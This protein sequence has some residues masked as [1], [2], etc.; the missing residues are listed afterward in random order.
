MPK[1]EYRTS[2]L[3]D[4]ERFFLDETCQGGTAMPKLNLFTTEDKNISLEAKGV[5]ETMVNL[6]EGDYHT[7]LELCMLLETDSLRTIREAMNEL[8]GA[9]YLVCVG[10]KYA[11][12][13]LRIPEMKLI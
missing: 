6:P 2:L 1:I 9:G 8:A 3:R 5:L 13:K 10:D 7:P 4:E 12:N 11:V